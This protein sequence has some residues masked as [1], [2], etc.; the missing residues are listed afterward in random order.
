MAWRGDPSHLRA[1][2]ILLILLADYFPVIARTPDFL[3]S[4]AQSRTPE[5]SPEIHSSRRS[6]SRF[7][8]RIWNL[9]SRLIPN[10]HATQSHP[11]S[12]ATTFWPWPCRSGT[13]TV[14]SSIAP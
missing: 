4:P 10:I 9:V 7:G 1:L 13:L 3:C 5:P 11:S 2:L 12:F 14:A 6:P 8:P